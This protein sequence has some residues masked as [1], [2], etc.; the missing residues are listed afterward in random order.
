ME[1]V[2][3]TKDE[4]DEILDIYAYLSQL[5]SLCSKKRGD[6]TFLH[7]SNRFLCEDIALKRLFLVKNFPSVFRNSGVNVKL[8]KQQI[9]EHRFWGRST[10]SKEY[11]EHLKSFK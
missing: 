8:I 4:K 9:K 3:L 2:K 1:K 7:D 11:I 10:N 6:N 5:E